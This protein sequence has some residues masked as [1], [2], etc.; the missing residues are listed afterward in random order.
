MDAAKFT[1]FALTPMQV[2]LSEAFHWQRLLEE[3]LA[4]SGT[5]IAEREHAN[6]TSINTHFILAVDWYLAFMNGCNWV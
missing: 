1:S 4:N 2:A 6:T 3:G 5:E